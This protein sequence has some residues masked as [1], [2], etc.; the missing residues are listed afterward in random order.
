MNSIFRKPLGQSLLLVTHGMVSEITNLTSHKGL[1]SVFPTQ[2][3]FLYLLH[4]LLFS[5]LMNGHYVFPVTGFYHVINFS[6]IAPVVWSLT[7]DLRVLI[8][9]SQRILLT[10]QQHCWIS[11]KHQSLRLGRLTLGCHISYIT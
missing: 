11:P 10:L 7:L 9:G 1:I 5:L 3:N 2:V 4:I 6:A 8:T